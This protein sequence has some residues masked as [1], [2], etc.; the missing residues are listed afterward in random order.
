MRRLIDRPGPGA[1][2]AAQAHVYAAAMDIETAFPHDHVFL[3]L[4]RHHARGAVLDLG[5]GMVDTPHGS[6]PCNWRH[7][8]M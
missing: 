8:R 2:D 4:L 5:G 7:P 1:F 6:S 3:E